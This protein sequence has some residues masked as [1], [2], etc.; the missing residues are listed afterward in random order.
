MVLNHV[1]RVTL[2]A[3]YGVHLTCTQNYKNTQNKFKALR[4]LQSTLVL[5]CNH[6]KSEFNNLH[7]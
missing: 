7:D 4:K 3:I 1:E 5:N 6:N 2:V